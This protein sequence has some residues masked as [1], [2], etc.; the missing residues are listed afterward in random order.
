[1]PTHLALEDLLTGATFDHP[2]QI[3]SHRHL[4]GRPLYH[5]IYQPHK[6]REHDVCA[7]ECADIACGR[8]R[9]LRGQ[10]LCPPLINSHKKFL[11]APN[12]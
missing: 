7:D 3:S 11:K 5:V 9:T 10:T 4:V 1:M 6:Q 2:K 12:K 8:V